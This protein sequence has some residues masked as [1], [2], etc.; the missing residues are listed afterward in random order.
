[1]SRGCSFLLPLPGPSTTC[2]EESCANQGVCLQQ[3]DGFTCD[4]TMTSYGGPV[5]NDQMCSGSLGFPAQSRPTPQRT[6]SGDS[7]EGSP[8]ELASLEAGCGAVPWF[9]TQLQGVPWSHKNTP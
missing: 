4:C 7:Q 8:L 1:M 2:T 6:G 3:W 9:S 5:C